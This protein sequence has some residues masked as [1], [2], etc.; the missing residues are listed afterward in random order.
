MAAIIGL[1]RAEI[2]DAIHASG[3]TRGP[4]PSS[5]SRAALS[6]SAGN[7]P[8]RIS[9]ARAVDLNDGEIIEAVANE[10]YMSH[11]AR[12][13][14]DFPHYEARE[15]SDGGGGALNVQR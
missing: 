8:T 9:R 15:A 6:C 13:P 7:W 3:P 4:M 1:N 10:N 12:V 5:N 11:V 14:I 2:D